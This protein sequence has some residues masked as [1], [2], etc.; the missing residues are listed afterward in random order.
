MLPDLISEI[1]DTVNGIDIDRVTVIDHGGSGAV[2]NVASQMPAAV[3]AITEQIETA[4]GVNILEVLTRKTTDST[5][6][7]VEVVDGPGA[8]VTE[9]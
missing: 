2:P 7:E 8:E 9:V 1:V 3:I 6:V 5:A 4:T